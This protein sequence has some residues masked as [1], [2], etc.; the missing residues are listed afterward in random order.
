MGHKQ[1]TISP[2]KAH[3]PEKEEEEEEDR[4]PEGLPTNTRPVSNEQRE[5]GEEE[6]ENEPVSSCGTRRNG[7]VRKKKFYKKM[8]Q[9]SERDD[10]AALK[11]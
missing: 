11:S 10:H 7:R 1:P 5:A 9:A 8:L 3:Y 6:N 4:D 2:R